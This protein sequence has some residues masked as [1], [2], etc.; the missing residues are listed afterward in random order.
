VGVRSTRLR[1][2]LLFWH[3]GLGAPREAVRAS[4]DALSQ[5]IPEGDVVVFNAVGGAPAWLRGV[6]PNV[7]LL[8]STFLGIRWLT[9]FDAWRERSSW[10]SRLECPKLA[11]PQDEYDHCDVLDEWLS[12]LGTSDVFTVFPNDVEL[13]Y[14]TRAGGAMFHST[15]TG[16]VDERLAAWADS[17]L[18]LEARANDVVYR[19]TRLP[20]WYGSQGQLKHEIA[21]RAIATAESVGLDID[22]ST[23]PHDAIL[24]PGWLSF[25]ASGRSALGCESGSSVVDRRGEIR[26]VVREILARE[27]NATFEHVASQMPPGWDD[28]QLVA[29]SPR[30]LEA[31]VTRTC[32]VLV[33]GE[34]GGLLMPWRHYVPVRR[35]LSDLADALEYV[36]DPAALQVIADCTYAE[37]ARATE[38]QASTFRRSISDALSRHALVVRPSLVPPQMAGLVGGARARVRLLA[39]AGRSAIWGR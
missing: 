32:Q 8:H 11:F 10:L 26:R 28:H 22:V 4:I 17:G 37:I 24:G 1:I 15:L 20:Y 12:E 34:Y 13:L 21:S 7:V 19:A 27:P 36:R 30:H 23:D 9:S 29:V 2:L 38:T 25:L 35:D 6:R 3:P 14:P 5:A 31:A 16:Y 18:P 33:E 39:E